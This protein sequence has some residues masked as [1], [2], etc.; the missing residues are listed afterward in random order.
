MEIVAKLP[1]FW[2]AKYDAEE[3]IVNDKQFP[4]VNSLIHQYN[5]LGEVVCKYD[6]LPME[7]MILFGLINGVLNELYAVE[8]ETG[9]FLLSNLKNNITTKIGCAIPRAYNSGEIIQSHIDLSGKVNSIIYRA[10]CTSSGDLEYMEFMFGH[11][12]KKDSLNI[13][14]GITVNTRDFQPKIGIKYLDNEKDILD[15][16]NFM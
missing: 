10:S 13:L 4:L 7:N 9:D 5:H 8:I 16:S 1:V 15:P 11:L 3:I 12:V 14:P 6:E 2:F